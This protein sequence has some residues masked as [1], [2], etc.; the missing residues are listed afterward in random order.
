M[1]Q[2][3]IDNNK[4]MSGLYET[5]SYDKFM[6]DIN[7]PVNRG[8]SVRISYDTI[9]NGYGYFEDRRPASNMDPYVVTSIVFSSTVN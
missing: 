4:R 1:P 2:F 6:F 9:N 7:K 5:S 3:G 8:A